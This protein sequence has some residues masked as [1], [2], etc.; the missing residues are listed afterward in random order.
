MIDQIRKWTDEQLAQALRNVGVSVECGTCMEIFCTGSSSEN[1]HDCEIKPNTPI[2]LQDSQSKPL[3]RFIRSREGFW[4]PLGDDGRS[5][6]AHMHDAEAVLHGFKP[7][8][9]IAIYPPIDGPAYESEE[10]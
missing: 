10:P 6:P 7:G 3:R 5:Y 2:V 9:I 1:P 8:V 4:V